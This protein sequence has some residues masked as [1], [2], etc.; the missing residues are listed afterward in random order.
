MA[1]QSCQAGQQIKNNDHTYSV[2][3]AGANATP[4]ATHAQMS[5]PVGS[6]R[7]LRLRQVNYANVV[8]T[9]ARSVGRKFYVRLSV[10]HKSNFDER[11]LLLP[12]CRSTRGGR[13][14]EEQGEGRTLA[15]PLYCKCKCR[16]FRTSY[17][18]QY[19][20]NAWL[21]ELPALSVCVFVCECVGQF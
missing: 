7:E 19:N 20:Y 4:T 3:M 11:R 8:E 17:V 15:T 21:L 2:C 16:T 5:T 18:Q 1:K 10:E 9:S 13:R 6:P 14:E 12:H